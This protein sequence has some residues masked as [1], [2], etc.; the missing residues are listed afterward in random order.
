M[1]CQDLFIALDLVH[2][3]LETVRQIAVAGLDVLEFQ[4]HLHGDGPRL[5]DRVGLRRLTQI[6][7]LAVIAE[8]ARK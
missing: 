2:G 7:E 4:P 6:H 8:V 5:I 1:P 3:G